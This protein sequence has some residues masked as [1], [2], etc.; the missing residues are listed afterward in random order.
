M[1]IYKSYKCAKKMLCN[2]K[3]LY[4]KKL[5]VHFNLVQNIL[6]LFFIRQQKGTLPMSW[7]MFL[8][9]RCSFVITLSPEIG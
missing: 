2:K 8:E 9:H 5:N 3:I 4:I 7:S 1:H 6:V